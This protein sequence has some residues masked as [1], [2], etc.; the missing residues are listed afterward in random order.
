MRIIPGHF[1]AYTFWLV[2]C[3]AITAY[4]KT[5]HLNSVIGTS[6]IIIGGFLGDQATHLAQVDHSAAPPTFIERQMQKH[7]WACLVSG[8]VVA[9]TGILIVL[10]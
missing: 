9:T 7:R 2:L 8:T 3:L 5:G 1:K 6:L 4:L 10:S